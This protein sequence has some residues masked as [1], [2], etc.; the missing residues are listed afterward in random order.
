M[1][2]LNHQAVDLALAQRIKQQLVAIETDMHQLTR[3]AEPP[4][5]GKGR[6]RAG[7]VGREHARQLRQVITQ[8]RHGGLAVIADIG[9]HQNTQATLLGSLAKAALARAG[10]RHPGL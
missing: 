8:R 4:Q 7:T 2:L 6:S 1:R 5:R 9:I 10:R 3:L